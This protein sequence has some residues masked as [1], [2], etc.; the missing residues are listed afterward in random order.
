MKIEIRMVGDEIKKIVLKIDGKEVT[1]TDLS[2]DDLDKVVESGLS[3]SLEI[4]KDDEIE[5]DE[6]VYHFFDQLKAE[7]GP[8]SDLRKKI[9]ELVWGMPET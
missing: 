1:F 5:K 9:D 6:E 3:D 2:V 7:T 8:Q 4:E